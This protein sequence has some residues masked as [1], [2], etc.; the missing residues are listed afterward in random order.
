MQG[1]ATP[2]TRLPSAELTGTPL[3]RHAR[4]LPTAQAFPALAVG[5]AAAADTGVDTYSGGLGRT[6]EGGLEGSASSKTVTPAYNRSN[7]LSSPVYAFRH[8][9]GAC[10]SQA[11]GVSATAPAH[12]H[13][14]GPNCRPCQRS[15]L[16]ALPSSWAALFLPLAQPLTRQ[17]MPAVSPSEESLLCSS[18]QKPTDTMQ[19]T[20]DLRSHCYPSSLDSKTMES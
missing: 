7:T 1:R 8:C 13:C 3:Q 4:P 16:P 17:V 9:P 11:A 12:P 20:D 14:P 6:P 18:P 15:Q 5:N 10:P 19:H 2:S